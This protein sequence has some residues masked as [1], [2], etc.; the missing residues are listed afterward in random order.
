MSPTY[1]VPVLWFTLTGLPLD[2]PQSMDAVY[3]YLVPP[4]SRA[5]IKDLGVMGGVSMAVST[6]RIEGDMAV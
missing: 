1:Q 5:E 3:Q 6:P 4:S 2:G